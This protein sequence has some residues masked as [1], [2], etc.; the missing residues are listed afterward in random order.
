M[1]ATGSGSPSTSRHSGGAVAAAGRAP[2]LDELRGVAILGVFL[3][4]AVAAVCRV[5]KDLLFSIDTVFLAPFLYGKYGV[6]MFFA[7][8]G[9]CIHMS[10]RRAADPSWGPFAVRR[11]FRIYPA[12]LLAVLSIFFWPW[13]TLSLAN[14]ADA[15]QFWMHLGLVHN[16]DRATFYAVNTAWWSIAIEVQLYA[17]YPLLCQLAARAGWRRAVLGA[18]AVELGIQVIRL[19]SQALT[20]T[21]LPSYIVASPFAYWGSWAVGA[22]VAEHFLAGTRSPI[23]GLRFD[24]VLLAGL[25]CGAVK[26]LYGFAFFAFALAT[27]VAMERLFAGAWRPPTTAVARL[28]GAHL[29]LLGKASYSFYLFHGPVVAATGPILAALLPDVSLPPVARFMVACAAYPAA[30]V[31]AC[32]IYRVVEVPFMELGRRLWVGSPRTVAPLKG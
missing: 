1:I 31:L 2:Y 5:S 17:V 22:L 27:A 23:A 25:V 32:V 21:E 29:R 3:V 10:H 16:F 28:A 30:L 24:L 9:F 11:F 13:T 15:Y 19:A 4:H 14:P 6:A 8:S 12:Y 7:I 20:G 18:A 26:P